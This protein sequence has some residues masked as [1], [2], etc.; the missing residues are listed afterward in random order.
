MADPQVLLDDC[1]FATETKRRIIIAVDGLDKQGKT[2]FALTAPKPIVFLDFDIGTEGVSG[3][4]QPNIV[5][6]QPFMFRP[7]EV[8]FAVQELDERAQQ[9][10]MMEAAAPVLERFRRTYLKA[11]RE[12]VMVN[13]KGK[14][15]MAR[16]VI[17]DTGSEAWELL[18][19][20][21]LG[22]VT[23]VKPHHYVAV[24]GLMRDIVRAGYDSDTNVI[25]LHKLKAEWK[26]S[27][28][29]K[30]RKTGTVERAGFTDMAF[31]VQANLLAFRAPRVDAPEQAWKWKSGEGVFEFVTQP[32]LDNDDLGFRLIVGNSRHN[33]G[34]EGLELAGD[35]LNFQTLAQLLVPESQPEDWTDVL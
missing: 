31:L 28:E 13:S 6:S 20:A 12:P 26:D 5:R 34:L 32:R 11:L 25:W 8:L 9:V 22:K 1:T 4:Q 23:Q 27:S 2:H 14:K 30:G 33:P 29:G 35:M 24:N 3:I 15:L 7:S 19:L 21:E 16:T 18:R 17:V 10:K